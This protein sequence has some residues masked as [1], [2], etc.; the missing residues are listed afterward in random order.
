MKKILPVLL[1]TVV[2]SAVIAENNTMP[3]SV[4]ISQKEQVVEL[5]VINEQKAD[6]D[7]VENVDN[8][9]E[10]WN[11]LDINKDDSISK[12]EAASNQTLF[13]RWDELDINKDEKLDFIEFS[14]VSE[15]KM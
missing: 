6:L 13:E 14:R 12:V 4:D 11:M 3:Q 1:I 10:L 2:S 5:A 7:L 9:L 15:Q 8:N